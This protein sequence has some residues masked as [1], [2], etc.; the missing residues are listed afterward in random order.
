MPELKFDCPICGKA[1]HLWFNAEKKVSFCFRCGAK[2]VHHLVRHPVRNYQR[3]GSNTKSKFLRGEGGYKFLSS[4]NLSIDGYEDIVFVF[5][6]LIAFKCTSNV[7]QFRNLSGEPKYWSRP[8]VKIHDY[9]FGLDKVHGD[10]CILVEGALDVLRLKFRS[11]AVFG[12]FISDAQLR[13]LKNNF[14][15]ITLLFDSD[16]DPYEAKR[17]LL[18]HFKV[19]EVR[20]PFGDPVDFSEDQLDEFISQA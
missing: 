7:F 20:L 1:K 15:E 9:L 5:D 18:P 2:N 3:F 10:S 6:N 4:R 17:K 11:C 12:H 14:E 19:K 13:L 16:I 8:G